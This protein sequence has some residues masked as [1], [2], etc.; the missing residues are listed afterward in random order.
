M[1]QIPICTEHLVE[2]TPTLN[3]ATAFYPIAQ[4]IYIGDMWAC[5]HTNCPNKIMLRNHRP[6]LEGWQ[7]GY[8]KAREEAT[9]RMWNR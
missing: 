7:D 3:G 2:M 6:L 9:V 4:Y 1:I 5:P 8:H